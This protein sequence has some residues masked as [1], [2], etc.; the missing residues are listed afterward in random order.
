MPA[1]RLAWRMVRGLLTMV[2]GI[3]LAIGV[4]ECGAR[5]FVKADPIAQ[6]TWRKGQEEHRVARVHQPDW[7][8]GWRNRPGADAD[9]DTAEFRVHLHINQ[10]GLRGREVT[11]KRGRRVLLV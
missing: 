9:F 2:F 11:P 6:A 10:L 1:V 4:A 8:L 7:R 3:L 5:T